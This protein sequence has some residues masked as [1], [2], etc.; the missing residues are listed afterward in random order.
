MHVTFQGSLGSYGR[1]WRVSLWLAMLFVFSQLFLSLLALYYSTEL[2]G[3]KFIVESVLVARY[4][5]PRLLGW[6]LL[7]STLYAIPKK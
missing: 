6:G 1:R 5:F 4:L 3:R 2:V 7:F